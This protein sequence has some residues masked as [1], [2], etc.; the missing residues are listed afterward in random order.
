MF[1]EKLRREGLVYVTSGSG[2]GVDPKKMIMQVRNW[3]WG[4]LLVG[5][6]RGVFSVAEIGVLG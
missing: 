1:K 4:G 2:G 6:G 3:W 5:R